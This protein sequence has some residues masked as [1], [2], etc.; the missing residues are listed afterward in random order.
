MFIVSLNSGFLH[1]SSNCHGRDVGELL[2]RKQRFVYVTNE[3]TN[4]H[5]QTHAHSWSRKDKETFVLRTVK[6]VF[7][8]YVICVSDGGK[9]YYQS[10]NCGTI[11]TWLIN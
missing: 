7:S 3:R 11:T 4:G 6:H 1:T 10:N 8:L 2:I 5:A 9:R